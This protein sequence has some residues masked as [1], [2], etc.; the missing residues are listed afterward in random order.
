MSQ[1]ISVVDSPSSFAGLP[2]WTVTAANSGRA[3]ICVASSWLSPPPS[4]NVPESSTKSP[5]KSVSTALLIDALVDAANVAMKPTR[6]T[7]I[8]SA[9]AVDAVRFGL[10]IAFCRAS[11]PLILV[12]RRIGQPSSRAAG[13]ASTGAST[14]TPTNVTRAPTPTSGIA[15]PDSPASIATD[16]EA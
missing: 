2:G 15:S 14:A 5:W 9:A 8:I 1:L 4:P 3:A 7:P 6:A 12:A 16:T 11:E 10:R 13:R